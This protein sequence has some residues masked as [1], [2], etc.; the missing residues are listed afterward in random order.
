MPFRDTLGTPTSSVSLLYHDVIEDDQAG[1]SGVTTEG[2]WRYKLPPHKFKRHLETIQESMFSP[3]LIT[4]EDGDRGVYM[5]FDDGG[6]SATTAARLLEEYGYR[7]HFFVI[8]HRVGDENY[9]S[10]SEVDRLVDAGHLVGSHTCTHAN[11]VA[12]DERRRREE[13]T[14]SKAELADR[15][16]SC[17]SI[18]IPMGMYNNAVFESIREAG[19]EHVFTSE[20]ERVFDPEETRRIGRWSVWNHSSAE[21]INAILNFNPAYCFRVAGRWKLLKYVKSTIGKD[22]FVRLRDAVLR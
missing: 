6:A 13:L 9:L 12:L 8:T 17:R 1:N 3:R 15:Y 14:E 18:S 7:G 10:W 2:S 4:E 19:Y 20:P 5:T 11:L 16:G 22:R 21:D